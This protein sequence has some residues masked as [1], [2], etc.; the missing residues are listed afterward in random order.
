MKLKLLS[1]NVKGM[2]DPAS[3]PMFRNYIQRINSLD[4][5]LVQEHKLRGPLVHELG[6][7]F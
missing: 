3:I 7:K 4:I 1:Y 5:L 2:N 6:D